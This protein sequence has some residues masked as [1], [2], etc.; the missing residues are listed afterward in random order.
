MKQIVVFCLVIF[1]VIGCGNVNTDSNCCDDSKNSLIDDAN[2]RVVDKNDT[3]VNILPPVVKDILPPAFV[4]LN[5]THNPNDTVTVYVHGFSGHGA[6][7]IDTIY[8]A[9]EH[10]SFMDDIPT[11]LGLPTINNPKDINKTNVFAAT[12][13]YGDTPPSYYTEQDKEDI[14]KVTEEFGGGIPRYA[15]IVAKYSKHLMERTGAKQVNFI[16]GSM[17][18]LVTRY[19]IEKNLEGLA[20]DKKIARWLTLEGVVNGNYAASKS[21]LFKIYN[22]VEKV[23]IDIKHMKYKWISKNLSNPRSVGKSPFYKDI[24]VGFETSTDD[25]AKEGLLTKLMLTHGQFQPNDGYQI[26][27]DTKLDV[28]APYRFLGEN[29]THTFIHDTHLGIK[30]N[31]ILW[32]GISNFITSNKRVRVTLQDVKVDDIKEKD[33]WYSKKLPAEIVF[34]SRVYSPSLKLQWGIDGAVNEQLYVGGV[35]PIIKYKKKHQ[36]KV[37]NQTLYD[38]FILPLEDSL[39]IELVAK[40]IDGDLRYKVYE[41]FKDRDYSYIGNTT[42]SVPL[43]DGIYSFSSNKF[44][45]NVKV[46]VIE[47]PFALLGEDDVADVQN[48]TQTDENQILERGEL[49]S[50]TKVVSK[51]SDYMKQRLSSL[52]VGYPSLKGSNISGVD[53]YKLIYTTIKVDGEKVNASALVTIPQ[54][55]GK[56]LP[57]IADLHGTIFGDDYSPTQNNPLTRTGTLISALKGYSVVMPDYLGYGKSVNLQHPY[58]LK[59]SLADSV[60]DAIRAT[61]ALYAQKGIDDGDKLFLMGYSEGGYATMATALKI[62]DDYPTLNLSAVAPMAGS[63]DLKLTADTIL[64]QESYPSAHLPVF[65]IYSYDYYLNLQMLNSTFKAPY[66]NMIEEYFAQKREAKVTNIT[67]P[68]KRDELFTQSFLENYFANNMVEFN[69]AIIQNSVSDWTPMMPMRLYHCEG[70]KIVTVKNSQTAYDNFIKN[71]ATDVELKL[72]PNGSH[73][74]CAIPFYMDAIEW[75]DSLR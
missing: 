71:G 18:A 1:G 38:D 26:A 8:G 54:I 30:N 7:K 17:G 75:F 29:P 63:Y 16:S 49:V 64:S 70:D 74:S 61:K 28:L 20:A 60:I 73:G 59:D 41:S 9:D 6:G 11:F 31:S 23:S 46:E 2:Q 5:K 42:F 13:Y 37:V 3:E 47:Y 51:N 25:S 4:D 10:E 32:A 36:T 14:A 65:F 67:L 21:I 34:E 15:L 39:S 72:M 62:Q 56:K 40:E 69:N 55:D 45:G 33:R 52:L 48:S 24:L 57:L 27:K 58:L 50:F 35:P 22:D 19:L 44:S 66:A 12:G 43:K 68:S 53:V